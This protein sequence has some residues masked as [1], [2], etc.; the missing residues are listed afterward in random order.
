MPPKTPAKRPRG[1]GDNDDT[2]NGS[3][4]PRS[5]PRR[6]GSS[7]SS[8]TDRG[9]RLPSPSGENDGVLSGQRPASLLPGLP[10]ALDR[11][12]NLP[13]PSSEGGEVLSGQRPA[14]S[15]PGPSST[16]GGAR[17]VGSG[18]PPARIRRSASE[19]DR[20]RMRSMARRL[21]RPGSRLQSFLR[22]TTVGGSLYPGEASPLRQV[23]SAEDLFVESAP[24]QPGVAAELSEG[25]GGS[26]APA[27][28]PIASE[29]EQQE[30]SGIVPFSKIGQQPLPSV[31]QHD[32]EVAR[33]GI[34]AAHD[35][36][37]ETLIDPTE[38]AASAQAA[39]SL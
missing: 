19:S 25:S 15:S 11:G 7:G 3:P 24:A 12:R 31:S 5:A 33:E 34:S 18:S 27:P 21:S 17:E 16:S 6:D 39:E 29:V 30:P 35:Y 32:E 2:T 28:A 8:V 26:G 10:P 37:L 20:S 36:L 1:E 14:S 9:G 13:A 4:R 38:A 23:E 22:S